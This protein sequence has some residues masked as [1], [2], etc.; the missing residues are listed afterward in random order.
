MNLYGFVLTHL[1]V[2]LLSRRASQTVGLNRQR[3][4]GFRVLDIRLQT[5][6]ATGSKGLLGSPDPVNGDH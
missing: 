4:Q 6:L 3:V 2:V 1:A 5:W